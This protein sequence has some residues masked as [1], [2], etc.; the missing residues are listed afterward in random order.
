[1]F[2]ARCGQYDPVN[3]DGESVRLGRRGHIPNVVR[4]VEEARAL[5]D[6]IVLQGEGA[7]SADP[8]AHIQIFRG[9]EWEL[10]DERA[11]DP[12]FDP[13]RNVVSNPLTRL[14]NDVRV[15]VDFVTVFPKDRDGGLQHDLLQFFNGAYEVSLGW[16]HQLFSRQGSVGE[17][18]AIET[19]A[20]LPLMSEVIRPIGELLPLVPVDVRWPDAEELCGLL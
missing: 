16:L 13:S 17:L 18:R 9:I 12:A 2:F 1:M 15:D 4:T 14:H 3:E 20:F 6:L 11:A 8:D 19:L 5:I 10:E 7:T